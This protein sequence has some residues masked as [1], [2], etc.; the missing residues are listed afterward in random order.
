[1]L[2]EQNHPG[3]ALKEFETELVNAPGRH[4]ALRGAARAAQLSGQ[5]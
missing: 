2:L 5:K 1:L 4:G 3:L